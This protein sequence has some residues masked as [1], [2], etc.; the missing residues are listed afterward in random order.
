M[1]DLSVIQPIVS[2][3]IGSGA[4]AFYWYVNNQ[5]DPTKPSAKF[6]P[7]KLVPAVVTGMGI[8]VLS[9]VAGFEPLTQANVAVQMGAYGLITAVIETGMKTIWRRIAG[10]QPLGGTS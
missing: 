8:G 3:A 7:V 9:V 6:D 2:A 1:T 5:A 4:V 10:Y